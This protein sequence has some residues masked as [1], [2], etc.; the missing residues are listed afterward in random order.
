MPIK[1]SIDSLFSFK[2]IIDCCR[3][4]DWKD[5]PKIYSSAAKALEAARK[6]KKPEKHVDTAFAAFWELLTVQAPFFKEIDVEEIYSKQAAAN[7]KDAK[8][9]ARLLPIMKRH[10]IK[11]ANAP[12]NDVKLGLILGASTL[13][14]KGKQEPIMNGGLDLL[15][16]V[17][18]ILTH[19]PE[20]FGRNH[21]LSTVLWLLVQ[22]GKV[23]MDENPH[24]YEEEKLAVS[25]LNSEYRSDPLG[26]DY[27]LRKSRTLHVLVDKCRLVIQ[28]P[29]SSFY[30]NFGNIWSLNPGQLDVKIVKHLNGTLEST[31]RIDT[32]IAR[33]TNRLMSGTISAAQSMPAI[34]EEFLS[35]TSKDRKIAKDQEV[36][37]TYE[38][39]DTAQPSEAE[40]DDEVK[41]EE[42][43]RAWRFR[44]DSGLDIPDYNRDLN[45]FASVP[46]EGASLGAD[47]GSFDGEKVLMA[48][49]ERLPDQMP[50]QAQKEARQREA[51]WASKEKE[52]EKVAQEA[53]M[54][55]A[56]QRKADK[57]YAAS[58]EREREKAVLR[59]QM[60]TLEERKRIAILK[61]EEERANAAMEARRVAE[62]KRIDAEQA[63][64]KLEQEQR[65]AARIAELKRAEEVKA[66]AAMEARRVAEASAKRVD[67]ERV[68]RERQEAERFAEE[69]MT[70][71]RLRKERLE[72]EKVQEET[73][74][75]SK[76]RGFFRQSESSLEIL[77]GNNSKRR[78]GEVENASKHVMVV[79]IAVDSCK[80]MKTSS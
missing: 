74:K 14:G 30:R 25:L 77:F 9:Q 27:K 37:F 67:D 40:K 45:G 64:A 33:S 31:H 63:T 19:D 41:Q 56:E 18:I 7:E 35:E 58:L 79:L 54:M 15:L 1:D 5:S 65:E 46:D 29:D 76:K 28:A 52:D 43:E 10:E 13:A 60:E 16:V 51:A 49:V 20:P 12:G 80:K 38:E 57:E 72:A 71:E 75:T 34:W 50:V 22:H 69:Q 70:I 36:T 59:L 21:T 47:K 17:K 66:T 2:K 39:E 68:K 26:M 8:T 6:S 44:V 42:K 3:Q 53:T 73:K 23:K 4:I 48:E 11:K 78:K 32:Q 55:E 62:A 61:E 24:F